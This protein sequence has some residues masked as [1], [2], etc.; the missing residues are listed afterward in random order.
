MPAKAGQV[1]RMAGQL[2][3]RVAARQAGRLA[4]ESA[5]A[6]LMFTAANGWASQLLVGPTRRPLKA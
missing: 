1:G 4:A 5:V 2:G 3:G 6:A